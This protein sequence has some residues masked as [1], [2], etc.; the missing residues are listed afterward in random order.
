MCGYPKTQHVDEAIKPESYMGQP[1]D[2]QRHIREISTDAYGDISFGGM[3]Q[4]T[5]KVNGNWISL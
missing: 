3:G 5:G 1:Y 2:K 4:K